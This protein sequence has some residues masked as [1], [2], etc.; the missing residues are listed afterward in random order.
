MKLTDFF[1]K[2]KILAAVLGAYTVMFIAAGTYMKATGSEL[3]WAGMLFLCPLLLG[4]AAGT[5]K[6]LRAHP[7]KYRTIRPQLL[8]LCCVLTSGLC[9][10]ESLRKL[11][12]V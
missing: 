5:Y 8:I 1:R 11:F 6:S 3:D 7:E 4:V 12:A 10:L 9:L 2:H